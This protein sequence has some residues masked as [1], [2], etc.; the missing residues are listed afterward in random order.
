MKSL[1]RSALTVVFVLVGFD[2]AAAIAVFTFPA[3]A[4]RMISA[5]GL[6]QLIGLFAIVRV[7]VRYFRHEFQ[8]RRDAIAVGNQTNSF[9]AKKLAAVILYACGGISLSMALLVVLTA[10]VTR[11]LLKPYMIL[12]LIPGIAFAVFLLLIA[13]RTHSSAV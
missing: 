13:Y 1:L 6:V 11:T 4:G 8:E 12:G 9:Q 7:G 5:I 10:V 2:V 3:Q